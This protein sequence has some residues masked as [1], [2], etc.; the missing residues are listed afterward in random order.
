MP[1]VLLTRSGTIGVISVDH[2]PVNALSHVVREGLAAALAAAAD[3]PK[4]KIILIICE[5]KTFFAGADIREF[6]Q[7]PREPRIR[8][9]AQQIE[10][11]AKPV[12]AAIHGTALGGGLELALGC[13]YRIAAAGARF[14]LPEVKLGLIPGGG[15]TQR[16]P[17]LIGVERALDLIVSGEIIDARKALSLG[18]VDAIV[19]GSLRD[20]ALAFSERLPARVMAS[21]RIGLRNIL[22]VTPE[23]LD[24]AE[25]LVARRA[26]GLLAPLHCAKAVRAAC[27]LPLADGVRAEAILA[28]GLV[29]TP[30]AR[31][32][33]HVFFSERKATGKNLL[34]AGAELRAAY[35][36]TIAALLR[37]GAAA[38]RL[39]AVLRRFGF[40]RIGA[41]FPGSADGRSGAHVRTDDQ[42][43]LQRV[44]HALHR[45]G[46]A[47][48]DE[49]A[50]IG[51]AEIDVTAIRTI[52]FPTYRGGPMFIK[53]EKI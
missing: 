11:G 53:G 43:I 3:D 1:P 42:V 47:C 5:G 46:E 23:W 49:A 6:G 20:E 50:G 38:S 36:E 9:L 32:L 22:G 2:P 16:L 28:E 41:H 35:V 48:F 30:Q 13:H 18:I 12:V 15:G 39:K 37:E 29:G 7:K 51:P 21:R 24:E 17:R 44:L 40:E 10:D 25:K 26:R 27:E 52:G 19:S 34:L 4:L 33:R 14:G 31:A 45:A 8:G